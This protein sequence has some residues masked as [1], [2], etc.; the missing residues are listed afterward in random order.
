MRTKN[1]YPP[2][3]ITPIAK[4]HLDLIVCRMKEKGMRESS[5]SFLS[6]LILEQPLPNGS[7]ESKCNQ[8]AKEEK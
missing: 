3:R 6:R 7:A 2:V 4:E 8:D 5:S 1:L